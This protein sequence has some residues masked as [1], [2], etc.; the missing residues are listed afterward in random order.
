MHH[1]RESPERRCALTEQGKANLLALL[2]CVREIVDE[3][4]V[5]GYTI[6][7]GKLLPP[8]PQHR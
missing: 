1:T 2:E 6:V 5:Q 4:L 8:P 7:D 3:L